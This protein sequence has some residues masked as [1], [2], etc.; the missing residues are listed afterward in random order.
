MT[1]LATFLQVQINKDYHNKHIAIQDSPVTPQRGET[2]VVAETPG[3][4][5]YLTPP[6]SSSRG[7]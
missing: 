2:E 6:V 7:P 3:L 5:W 4:Y 1:F